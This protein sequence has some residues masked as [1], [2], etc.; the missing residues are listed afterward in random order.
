[1]SLVE[2]VKVACS[3]QMKRLAETIEGE[4]KAE[5]PVGK[6]GQAVGSIHIEQLGLT[7]YRIGGKNEHL[8]YSDQG[9]GATKKY[10][11]FEPKGGINRSLRPHNKD[12]IVRS[13]GR[14]AIEGLHFVREVADRH[15]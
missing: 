13:Q 7:R 9:S 14:K 15:R 1:M 11:A 3:E 10:I 8:Y 6:T 12:G 4:L 5:C 2:Q